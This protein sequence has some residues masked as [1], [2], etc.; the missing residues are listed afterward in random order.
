[1]IETAF[2]NLTYCQIEKLN[3]NFIDET[4]QGSKEPKSA[5]WNQIV[6]GMVIVLGCAT[7]K[8][9]LTVS[10]MANDRHLCYI[11]YVEM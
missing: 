7:P 8:C 10:Y 11:S 2:T 4:D 3:Q 6:K 1:M 5:V 9:Y